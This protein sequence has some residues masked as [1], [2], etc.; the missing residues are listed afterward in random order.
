MS[1]K[2]AIDKARNELDAAWREKFPL[3]EFRVEQSRLSNHVQILHLKS[4]PTSHCRL[5]CCYARTNPPNPNHL[6][7]WHWMSNPR[8]WK[9]AWKQD[10]INK[11]IKLGMST[12]SANEI[13]KGD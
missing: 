6:H 11:A 2:A 13:H 4:R 9:F 5:I 12:I 8:V 3:G 1:V 7:S 10:A